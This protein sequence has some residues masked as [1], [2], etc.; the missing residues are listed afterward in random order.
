V[1]QNA[2]FTFTFRGQ[3]LLRSGCQKS[4]ICCGSIAIDTAYSHPLLP[5]VVT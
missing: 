4:G 2:Y 3:R 1:R 5:D